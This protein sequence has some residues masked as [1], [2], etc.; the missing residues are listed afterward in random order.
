[1]SQ[2][3][4]ASGPRKGEPLS[5]RSYTLRL[6]FSSLLTAG[7]VLVIGIG[8]AFV[9]GVMVGRGYNPE[10]KVPQLA[11]LL[12]AE[13]SASPAA[14]EKVG[15][16][17]PKA[18]VMK[19]EELRYASSLKGK[20]GQA[21]PEPKPKNM[22]NATAPVLAPVALPGAPVAPPAL[23]QDHPGGVEQKPRVEAAPQGGA[24]FDFVFQVAT[25][26][27][28]DSVDKLRARLEGK[29][30]RTRMDKD[31]KLLKVMVL[32]RGTA[33][34]AQGVQQQMVEMGLGQP[35][36]RGKSPVGKSR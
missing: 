32:L 36:Q 9:L 1:M 16:A 19:P 7:I 34:A 30:L 5:K 28:S 4:S 14:R 23:A 18:E 11:T 27:D 13:Q 29:G 17:L 10:K 21:T 6:T 15:D 20:P 12:P 35:I 31:G 22:Q 24:M 2:T 25:F 3:P 26:K 33:D 8:W